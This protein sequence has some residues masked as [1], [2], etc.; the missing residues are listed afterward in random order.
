M[1]WAMIIADILKSLGPILSAVLK[2]WLD[3]KLKVAAAQFDRPP[4][5]QPGPDTRVLLERVHE[6]LW[7]WEPRRK[8]FVLEAI[9]TAPALVAGLRVESARLRELE[10]SAKAAA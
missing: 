8:R 1:Q 6:S 7:F 3:D 4:L 10:A 9:R 2:K 5:G